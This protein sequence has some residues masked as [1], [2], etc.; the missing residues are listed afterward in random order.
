ME[1][2]PARYHR[3]LRDNRTK[4]IGS[5]GVSCNITSTCDIPKRW[6]L[7]RILRYILRQRPR[8]CIHRRAFPALW[9]RVHGATRV[10]M[11]MGHF[12]GPVRGYMHGRLL[13]RWMY[14]WTKEI[15]AGI[16]P[17]DISGETPMGIHLHVPGN[18]PIDS[19]KHH[20]PT[21]VP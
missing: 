11:S 14:P 12:H 9:R 21:K 17:T 20:P 8:V 4:S 5:W 1:P 15:V 7:S 10:R 16:S 3:T 2:P 19:P 13:S 6:V 18:A